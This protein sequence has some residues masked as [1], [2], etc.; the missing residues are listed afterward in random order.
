MKKKKRILAALLA[1]CLLGGCA[2]RQEAPEAQAPVQAEP[3]AQTNMAEPKKQSE[4]P[5]ETRVG[6]FLD[7]VITLTAYT[8]KPELL[9]QGLELCGEYEK[10]LSRTIEGSDVW[11]I[12]H[13]EGKTVTVSTETAEILRTAVEVGK[14][15]GGAFDITIAP[16]SVLWDFNSGEKK[17]PD[18]KAVEEE[19]SQP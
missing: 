16:V 5:K 8:D 10:M 15:S 4:L 13:A 12:N 19:N 14:L 7:T 3:E 17:I 9:E 1:L 11:R 18:R 2:Q 6:F